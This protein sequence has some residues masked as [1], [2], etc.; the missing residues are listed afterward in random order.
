MNEGWKAEMNTILEGTRLVLTLKEALELQGH[1]CSISPS[2][3]GHPASVDWCLEIATGMSP[4]C[5]HEREMVSQGGH[6]PF[7]KSFEI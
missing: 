1:L 7:E 5:W 3:S 6:T 4:V 2:S